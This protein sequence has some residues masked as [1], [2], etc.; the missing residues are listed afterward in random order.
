MFVVKK[1]KDIFLKERRNISTNLISFRNAFS[2]K[3]AK[4]G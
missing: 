3:L 1:C 2:E 4:V